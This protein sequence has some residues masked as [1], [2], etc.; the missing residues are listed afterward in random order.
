MYDP[1]V[2]IIVDLILLM[3]MAEELLRHLHCIIDYSITIPCARPAPYA[4]C[5]IRLFNCYPC[6]TSEGYTMKGI[7]NFRSTLA[8]PRSSQVARASEAHANDPTPPCSAG[9]SHKHTRIDMPLWHNPTWKPL[10]FGYGMRL[11]SGESG[12]HVLA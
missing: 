5:D 6:M 11:R 2:T 10:K 4:P 3:G 1:P 7:C 9:A 12:G 8:T